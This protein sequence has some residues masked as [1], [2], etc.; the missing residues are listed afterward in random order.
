MK[1]IYITSDMHEAS[2]ANKSD[3]DYVMIDLEVN[4]K[5]ERQKGRDTLI[6]NHTFE[7]VGLIRGVLTNSK[8]MVRINPFYKNTK[9]EVDTSIN[10]GAD[11]LMLPMFRSKKEVEGFLSLVDSRAECQI[12]LETADGLENIDSILELNGIS[13]VHVGLNDL[14]QELKLNF[15]F[16]LFLGDLLGDLGKKILDR[17]INFG[18][19]GVGRPS[20]SQLISPELIMREHNRIG[21]TQVILSR[22]FRKVFLE[23][24]N[25]QLALLQAE[26]KK[27][28]EFTTATEKPNDELVLDR[29]KL[30]SAILFV[31]NEFKDS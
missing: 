5:S 31:S 20:V 6:S 4:G 7:D 11:C 19:G 15:M 1:L 22:D 9:E 16:E 24:E 10:F 26:C 12:L 8:L 14:H 2:T 3:V 29:K 21:S 23:K 17:G 18:I 13:T 25:K 27:I 28:R 30:I